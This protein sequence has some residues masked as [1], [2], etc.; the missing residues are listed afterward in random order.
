[1]FLRGMEFPRCMRD[2]KKK[3]RSV[4]Q[5]GVVALPPGLTKRAN[6]VHSSPRRR[7]FL[8]LLF[9]PFVSFSLCR[10][11]LPF[12]FFPLQPA[13][14][15]CLF[16]FARIR[17]ALVNGSP[18]VLSHARN[19]IIRKARPMYF[20]VYYINATSLPAGVVCP[21][22]TLIPI[23]EEKLFPRKNALSGNG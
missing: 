7:Q 2:N 4:S 11:F 18:R 13:H 19:K 20:Y 21:A 8:R 12:S 17:A 10:C 16:F 3:K 22:E 14:L 23:S 15:R 5:R 6:I 1:M 9:R